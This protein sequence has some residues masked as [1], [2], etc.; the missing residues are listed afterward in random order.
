MTYQQLVSALRATGY[1]V[2]YSHFTETESTPVPPPPFICYVDGLSENFIADNKVMKKLTTIEIELYTSKKDLVAEQ[3]LED[4]LD[5]LNLPYNSD[6]VI[7]I[8]DE[9]YFQKIYEVRMI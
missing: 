6:G 5:S 7:W 1:P 2:A 3:K 9:G 4:A 8:E